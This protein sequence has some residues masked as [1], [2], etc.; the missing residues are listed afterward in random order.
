MTEED[1]HDSTAAPL[2][3]ISDAESEHESLILPGLKDNPN[4]SYKNKLFGFLYA[5][6]VCPL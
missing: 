6:N 5:L 2:Q 3:L 4:M 1:A